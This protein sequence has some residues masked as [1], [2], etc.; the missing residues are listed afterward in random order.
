MTLGVRKEGSMI[1][2][3]PENCLSLIQMAVQVDAEG[4]HP[5][6]VVSKDILIDE[7]TNARFM[8]VGG[9][10]RAVPPTYND[11]ESAIFSFTSDGKLRTDASITVGAL[12]VN[13]TPTIWTKRFYAEVSVTNVDQTVT[14]IDVGTGLP[15]NAEEVTIGNDSTSN[16]V[17][18]NYGAAAIADAAHDKVKAGEKFTDQFQAANVHLISDVAGPSTVRVWARAL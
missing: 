9:I 14:F 11:G 16:S 2:D 6:N 5:R 10:Y 15:F 1:L 17:W 3:N 18:L 7:I 8:A 13:V 4:Y 12:T